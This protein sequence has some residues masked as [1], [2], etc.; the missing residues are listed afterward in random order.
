MP[1]PDPDLVEILIEESMPWFMAWCFALA[2]VLVAYALGALVL[3]V[4]A[5][6]P[7]EKLLRRRF[8]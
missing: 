3:R 7:V 2:L 4:R 5:R 6:S 8:G 1:F